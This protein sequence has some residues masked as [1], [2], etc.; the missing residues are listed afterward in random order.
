MDR[1]VPRC[2]CTGDVVRRIGNA[3][4]PSCFMRQCSR[5]AILCRI[6]RIA[7]TSFMAPPAYFSRSTSFFFR[8][9]WIFYR[10]RIL[11][12]LLSFWK[13]FFSSY[14]GWKT[15]KEICI[16]FLW[17]SSYKK[18]RTFLRFM[19]FANILTLNAYKK[20]YDYRF[21]IWIKTV[22]TCIVDV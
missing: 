19:N 21:S 11:M 17:I 4:P 18:M 8:Y 14:K 7:Y 2:W 15:N 6:T 22:W 9:T 3:Q 16:K 20:Y 13:N 10:N 5:I 12:M 1:S